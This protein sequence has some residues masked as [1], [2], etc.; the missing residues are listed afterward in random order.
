MNPIEWGRVDPDDNPVQDYCATFFAPIVLRAR[1]KH[2]H[3]SPSLRSPRTGVCER[4]RSAPPGVPGRPPWSA[5]RAV[6]LLSAALCEDDWSAACEALEA[7]LDAEETGPVDIQLLM[8]TA[9]LIL[10][11]AHNDTMEHVVGMCAAVHRMAQ[12]RSPVALA[13]VLVA[14]SGTPEV[15]RAWEGA[16]LLMATARFKRGGLY[17]LARRARKRWARRR[18]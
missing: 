10:L 15:R 13:T 17:R 14:F 2:S 5:R 11:A 12:T 8:A 1:M 3:S 16:L 7:T 9:G 18:G 4:P 6:S